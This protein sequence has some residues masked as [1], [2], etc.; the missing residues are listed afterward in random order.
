[1]PDGSLPLHFAVEKGS[2]EAVELLLQLG[3]QPDAFGSMIATPLIVAAIQNE[4]RKVRML[5][6]AGADPCVTQRGSTGGT[7]LLHAA[8]LC[9]GGVVDELLKWGASVNQ[10]SAY[11]NTPLDKALIT[12]NRQS[13]AVRA[14][15]ADLIREYG[16]VRGKRRPRPDELFDWSRLAMREGR[17][18]EALRGITK[19]ID[20][21]GADANA[22]W[23]RACLR[24]ELSSAVG[25]VE[26]GTQAIEL[27]PGH[28]R[29]WYT[30]GRAYLVLGKNEEALADFEQALKI[31]PRYGLAHLGRGNAL[32]A[33]GAY[34]GAI[35]GFNVAIELT[36]WSS[37]AYVSRAIARRAL[38]DVAGAEADL[39][40]ARSIR[41]S[42]DAANR[43]REAPG[44]VL[45]PP[46]ADAVAE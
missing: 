6:E 16:G 3:A 29:A 5:L 36:P 41:K 40:M 12:H 30:R 17:H 1:M 28:R 44:K 19:L 22:F 45:P 2:P 42:R 9:H 15:V 18:D 34:E 46:G 11:G 7:A 10:A 26:D 35:Q 37:A 4:P 43:N 32:G 38:G 24:I 33:M 23:I 13:R 27:K 20:G 21:G 14:A 39:K 8:A 25:A 31:V